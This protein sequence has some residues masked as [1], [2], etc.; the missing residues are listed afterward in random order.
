M[1]FRLLTVVA[2]LG[3]C[4]VLAACGRAPVERA[5]SAPA[6]SVSASRTVDGVVFTLSIPSATLE[7][8]TA[9]AATITITNASG[10]STMTYVADAIFIEDESGRIVYDSLQGQKWRF[11]VRMEQFP[12][13]AA[14]TYHREIP[15]LVPRVGTYKLIVWKVLDAAGRSL[16]VG[17]RSIPRASGG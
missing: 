3:C 15:F 16:S 17:F 9:S 14:T 8:G 7:E 4:G 1:H 10:V 11:F 12:V 5:P 2:L 6:Q 13:P